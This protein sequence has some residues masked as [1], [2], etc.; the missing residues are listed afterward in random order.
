VRDFYFDADRLPG[1]II[2]KEEE[3]ANA[4]RRSLTVPPDPEKY[5]RFL[6]DFQPHPGACAK[7]VLE[8]VIRK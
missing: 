1:E 5:D 6:A 7:E 2:T 4:V 8:H 3:L